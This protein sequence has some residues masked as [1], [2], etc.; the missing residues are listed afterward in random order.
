MSLRSSV[1]RSLYLVSVPIRSTISSNALRMRDSGST[2]DPS[3]VASA[4]GRRL[5]VESD[6]DTDALGRILDVL[7]RR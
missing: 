3:T 2:G 1:Y 4:G 7:E 6:I 5:R